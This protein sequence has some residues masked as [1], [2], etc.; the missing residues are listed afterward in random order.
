MLFFFPQYCFAFISG[1]SGFHLRHD[2]VKVYQKA[3][4]VGSAVLVV[5]IF[6]P[7]C[8]PSHL[9][10]KNSPFLLADIQGCLCQIFFPT[11]FLQS[12][13]KNAEP[14]NKNFLGTNNSASLTLLTMSLSRETID[15]W[16]V[17]L[18]GQPV[19]WEVDEKEG[20][21]STL[22]IMV[23]QAWKCLKMCSDTW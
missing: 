19:F 21:R 17:L 3:F 22:N 9:P 8:P 15:E 23:A 10:L 12:T 1:T 13:V 5:P 7:L 20:E 16:F 14:S 4:S 11:W 18:H 2:H 6:F